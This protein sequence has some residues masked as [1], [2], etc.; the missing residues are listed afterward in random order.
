MTLQTNGKMSRHERDDLVQLCRQREKLAKV[1]ADARASEM[2]ADFERQLAAK[3]S[4]DNDEVWRQSVEITRTQLDDA[5]RVIAERSKELG[6]P[7]EFAPSLHMSWSPRGENGCKENRTELRKVADSRIEAMAKDA[8]LQIE[9]ASV[10]VRTRLIAGSLESAD[11]RS[12]LESM[13]TAAELMPKCLTVSE[14]Q[15]MLTTSRKRYIDAGY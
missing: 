6:I 7:A 9:A 2:R 12:F 4:F 1:A 5:N 10:E 11:A 13:P 14:V 8:K 3:F 15:G